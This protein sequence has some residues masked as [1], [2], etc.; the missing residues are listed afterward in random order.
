MGHDSS[1]RNMIL[2]ADTMC[3]D[4]LSQEEISIHHVPW[5]IVTGEDLH[6]LC[7]MTQYH[8]RRSPFTMC[9][10]SISQEEISIHYVPWLIVTGRHLYSPCAMTMRFRGATANGKVHIVMSHMTITRSPRADTMCHDS[11]S[12]EEM[13]IY[14]WHD[15][16][17]R[18]CHS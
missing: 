9:H 16:A 7:A 8:R 15:Y 13:S 17:L 12:Q 1:M 3:H 6:L 5:L 4:S 14:V 11:M 2:R 18:R 10:D